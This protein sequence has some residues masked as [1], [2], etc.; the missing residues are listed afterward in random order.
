VR[1]NWLIAL[2]VAVASAAGLSYAAEPASPVDLME[3]HAVQR[4]TY[5]FTQVFLRPGRAR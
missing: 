3:R 4:I 1:G 5:Y 2:V